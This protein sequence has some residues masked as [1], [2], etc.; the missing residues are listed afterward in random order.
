MTYILWM[1]YQMAGRDINQKRKKH[2]K[3][4]VVV[5]DD[6]GRWFADYL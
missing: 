6:S 1:G 5:P 4:L 2:I 3:S